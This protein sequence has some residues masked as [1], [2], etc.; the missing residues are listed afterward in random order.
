MTTSRSNAISSSAIIRG[1]LIDETYAVF[2]EWD[3]GKSRTENLRRVRD[4]NTIAAASRHWA[5]KI[6]KAISRRFDPA[7][8]DRPLTHLAT[9]GCDREL[10]KPILLHMTRDEFL[11]RDFLVHW[12]YPHYTRGTYRLHTDDVVEY[13]STLGKK[14]GI[15]WSGRWT[16]STTT[17]VASGLLR[18]ATDFDLLAIWHTGL[19]LRRIGYR[20]PARLVPRFRVPARLRD[21]ECRRRR[22]R[23]LGST[24]RGIAERNSAKTGAHHL[25]F[26]RSNGHCLVLIK[27]PCAYSDPFGFRAYFGIGISFVEGLDV[28]D[29]LGVEVVLG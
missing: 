5:S 19:H 20:E 18:L 7:G 10:W 1:S 24:A 2:R 29:R 8:R 13:L 3:F 25:F 21:H 12:L 16:E 4:E 15:E 6:T 26:R 11:L 17:R 22:Y 28:F 14:K 9:A 23:T 27:R